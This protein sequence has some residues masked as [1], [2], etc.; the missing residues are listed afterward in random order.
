MKKNKNEEDKDVKKKKGSVIA[1]L[2]FSILLTLLVH[3]RFG[4][5]NDG[6]METMGAPW[7]YNVLLIAIFFASFSFWF[8]FSKGILRIRTDL[9]DEEKKNRKAFRVEAIFVIIDLVM[10][11]LFVKYNWEQISSAGTMWAIAEV[12]AFFAIV[13]FIFEFF[14]KFKFFPE[15]IFKFVIGFFIKVCIPMLFL[16]IILLGAYQSKYGYDDLFRSQISTNSEKFAVVMQDAYSKLI[17]AFYD[18]GQSNPDLWIWLPIAAF[19]IMTLWLLY[20]TFTRKTKTDED[21]TAQ[22]IIDETIKEEQEE[23]AYERGEK[24]R[25]LLYNFFKKIGDKFESKKAK[26][27]ALKEKEEE[28]KLKYNVYDI[29]LILTKVKGGTEK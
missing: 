1:A 14:N 12:A 11:S 17:T 24:K 23:L 9:T 22:E 29:K 18:I 28:K 27:K 6:I 3:I 13:W 2:I 21:K 25:P 5:G 16:L 8:L 19:I 10:T 26:E 4:I 15:R 20:D 7:G